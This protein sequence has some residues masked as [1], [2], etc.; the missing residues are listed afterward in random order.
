MKTHF[1]KSP[2]LLRKNPSPLG[3]KGSTQYNPGEIKQIIKI[4]YMAPMKKHELEMTLYFYYY[5]NIVRNAQRI[6]RVLVRWTLDS[7][8]H[9]YT[10]EANICRELFCQVLRNITCSV[11]EYSPD[12]SLTIVYSSAKRSITPVLGAMLTSA[13]QL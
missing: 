2:D 5:F 13:S 8:Y 10:L 12:I 4:F 3:K 11:V 6:S 7:M 1:F 9:A